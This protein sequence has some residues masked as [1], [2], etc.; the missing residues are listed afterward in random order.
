MKLKSNDPSIKYL[1][2]TKVGLQIEIFYAAEQ[3]DFIGC[4]TNA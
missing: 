1:M 4:L 3:G 2:R